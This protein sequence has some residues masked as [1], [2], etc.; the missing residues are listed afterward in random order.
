[1][2]STILFLLLLCDGS[3]VS[4]YQ[5][6]MLEVNHK[7]CEC[8]AREQFVQVILWQWSPDYRR[9]HVVCWWIV[10]SPIETPS[11]HRQ[12]VEHGGRSIKYLDFRESWTCNDPE[13]DNREV[14]P[15]S[16]RERLYEHAQTN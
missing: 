12:V 5:V 4:H 13:R 16:E 7:L 10:H 11:R 2:N 3:R 8:D 14:F 9:Y 6:D 15:E 1:M